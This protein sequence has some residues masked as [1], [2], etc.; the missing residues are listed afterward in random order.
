MSYYPN[1]GSPFYTPQMQPQIQ[2]YQPMDNQYSQFNQPQQPQFYKQQIGLQG[3]SVDSVEVV[4]AMDIPL[5]G[6]I[7]YFPLTDG[8]AIIS[9]QL[10]MD[11]TS[12]TIIYEPVK[13]ENE[14]SSTPKYLTSDEFN[15]HMQVISQNNGILEQCVTS[16]KDQLIGLADNVQELIDEVKVLKGGKK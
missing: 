2:R 13:L 7:S 6:S 1:Y 14:Q 10:Q 3:K 5:D 11:G 8:S 4:K 16:I 15:Q 12:K 9:K